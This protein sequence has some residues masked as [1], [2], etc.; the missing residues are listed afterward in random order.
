M[1]AYAP[2]RCREAAT[3]L[4]PLGLWWFEDICD[5]LDF[6]T[7]A[8]AARA[9]DPPIAAGEALFSLAAPKPLHRSGGRLPERHIPLLAPGDCSALRITS[10]GGREGKDLEITVVAGSGAQK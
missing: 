7:L 8:V 6:D 3:A 1:N 9:Y 5:P 10:R 4:A 2:E